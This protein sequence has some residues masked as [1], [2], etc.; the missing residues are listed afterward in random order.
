MS[1]TFPSSHVR[2][3]AF[4]RLFKSITPH[5]PTRPRCLPS[6]R[7]FPQLPP[8]LV[9]DP[10]YQQHC[11]SRIVAAV[12]S[13]LAVAD[14]SSFI[15]RVPHTA[16]RFSALFPLTTPSRNGVEPLSPYP[17]SSTTSPLGFVP[18]G[19]VAESCNPCITD[20]HWDLSFDDTKT[21][22]LLVP[23]TPSPQGMLRV[24]ATVTRMRHQGLR[25]TRER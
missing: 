2:C 22:H 5:V 8:Q 25:R 24:S 19:E 9:K 7:E 16:S 15:S 13:R 10:S 3:V 20:S 23:E 6:V 11:H 12:S 4:T 17:R 18:M 14:K 1:N 21:P